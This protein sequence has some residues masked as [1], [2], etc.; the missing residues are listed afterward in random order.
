MIIATHDQVTCPMMSHMAKHHHHWSFFFGGAETSNNWEH[1]CHTHLFKSINIYYTST[2]YICLLLWDQFSFENGPIACFLVVSPAQPDW[3]EAIAC[4]AK[5]KKQA[6]LASKAPTNECKSWVVRCREIPQFW[7]VLVDISAQFGA[8]WR[9][10]KLYGTALY[11]QLPC[12]SGFLEKGAASHFKLRGCHSNSHACY[13]NCP[14]RINLPRSNLSLPTAPKIQRT[15]VL[16]ITPKSNWLL[17][18]EAKNEQFQIRNTIPAVRAASGFCFVHATMNV[19]SLFFWEVSFALRSRLAHPWLHSALKTSEHEA[20]T[21]H[22]NAQEPLLRSLAFCCSLSPNIV[23]YALED[24]EDLEVPAYDSARC[25]PRCQAEKIQS[26]W[27]R[28]AIWIRLNEQ[29]TKVF[30]CF[31][32]PNGECKGRCHDQHQTC[33]IL[34]T[35]RTEHNN[36]FPRMAQHHGSF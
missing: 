6:Y 24:L 36:A 3:N 4:Q 17:P 31:Q 28:L 9:T 20:N 19:A 15:A 1:Q 33:S 23:R 27:S 2:N 13:R 16:A 22:E 26:N 7:Q 21:R 5:Q 11:D 35:G 14:W 25:C 29:W 8:R 34:R 30:N 12:P 32:Q 10:Y 18:F